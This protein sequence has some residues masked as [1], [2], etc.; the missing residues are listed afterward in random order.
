MRRT[1]PHPRRDIC[2][3]VTDAI[4]AELERGV[5]PWVRPWNVPDP[6]LPRNGATGRGYHGLNVVLLWAA[7]NRNGYASQQW[8]TYKQAQELGG[9]VRRGERSS[10]VTFWKFLERAERDPETGETVR[11]RIP[12]L[13]HYNV[14]NREQCDG[15]P[16]PEASPV[17]SLSEQERHERAERFMGATG[18]EIRHGGGRAFYSP[19]GD[20]VQLPPFAT[21]RDGASYYGT[22]CH[23][24]AHWSGQ[25]SRCNRTFGGRF[26]DDAY[27]AEELVAELG[28][29]FLC[30]ELGIDG[31]LQ[32][33]EYLGNWLQVLRNDKRAIFTAASKAREAAEYLKRAAGWEASEETAEEPAGAPEGLAA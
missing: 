2:R 13:R 26:G 6:G 7:A 5:A 27:A 21:F 23:E 12:L 29:A 33:P 24:L 19:H 32:H 28:A 3:E 10:L 22:A 31:Q 11:K 18:A 1:G 17:A 15:L 4:V 16:E 8:F 25:P 20:Y 30:A 14:F 9:H